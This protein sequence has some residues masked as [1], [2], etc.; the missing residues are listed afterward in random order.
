VTLLV[1]SPILIELLENLCAGPDTSLDQPNLYYRSNSDPISTAINTNRGRSIEIMLSLVLRLRHR[2]STYAD[3][4]RRR[5]TAIFDQRFAG[6]PPLSDPEQALL[7]SHIVS[8][9]QVDSAWT[10][11]RM[12]QIYG[13]APISHWLLTF[14]SFL[15]FNH[16]SY[17]HFAELKSDYQFALDHLKALR[18]ES[19]GQNS[20]RESALD[21]LGMHL[22]SH[23]LWEQYALT[24]QDSLLDVFITRAT[25]PEIEALNRRLSI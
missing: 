13:R 7:G 1:A 6:Q 22:F 24:G 8:L 14:G 23:Y 11:G 3:E 4:A 16:A 25:V 17:G 19:K 2:Q 10:A 21:S 9:I 5:I 15:R 12:N 18:K 20:I